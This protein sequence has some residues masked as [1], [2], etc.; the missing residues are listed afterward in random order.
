VLDAADVR[1]AGAILHFGSGGAMGADL[2]GLSPREERGSGAG[3][4]PL[5]RLPASAL[6]LLAAAGAIVQVEDGA[7]MLEL[8]AR[9]DP[10]GYATASLLAVGELLPHGPGLE[11]AARRFYR[12]RRITVEGNARLRQR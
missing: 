1:G 4:A 11:A 12:E 5:Q 2:F 9:L 10:A 7:A 3:I 8:L 6:A